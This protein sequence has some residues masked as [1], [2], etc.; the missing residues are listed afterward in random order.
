MADFE[1]IK[2]ALTYIDTHL[3]EPI[4]LE[5][6]ARRFHFSP[7][8]FHRMFTA[9]V[10]QPLAVFIRERRLL[11]AAVLLVSTA[12][13]TL[14]IAL[15][16]GYAS[17]PAFT[18]AFKSANAVA[19]GVYRKQNTTPT[20]LTIDE[21]IMK[22]TNR[23]RG[24]IDL[25][26][27]IIKR[28]ALCIAGV[29]GD[30]DDTMAVWV[31]Y[32]KLCTEH[33]LRHKLSDNGY[34][35]RLYDGQTCTVHVGA[36]V[37][38][39][40]ADAPYTLMQLPPSQYAAFDV[41]VA[42]GYESENSAMDEWLRTNPEGYTERLLDGSHYCVEYYDERFHGSEAGSIVE[43]WVPIEKQPAPRVP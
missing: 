40:Q 19:P 12:M 15:A 25:N 6:L 24:G 26:P 31:A 32:E 41:Y 36:A 17:T 39:A 18:R 42:N 8:Y 29:S 14:D 21:I 7:Y 10:G 34:E 1:K 2:Q 23:L 28:E 9:I 16:C 4:L 35:I 27:N 37:S 43:I 38:T 11:H 22:F 20:M 33:P 13:P 5:S 30:G 3:D